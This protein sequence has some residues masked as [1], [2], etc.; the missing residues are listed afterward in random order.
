M[1]L[2]KKS[3]IALI[4]IVPFLLWMGTNV[5]ASSWGT[6]VV[7]S[8][9]EEDNNG[10]DIFHSIV[11]N[12]RAYI[13]MSLP[14]YTLTD[15][16]MTSYV[17]NTNH[18]IK[19]YDPANIWFDKYIW[20]PDTNNYNVFVI[21]STDS[22]GNYLVE[23]KS[24][25][26]FNNVLRI[27]SST[28]SLDVIASIDQEYGPD[29]EQKIYSLE[30]GKTYRLYWAKSSIF[31]DI[32]I[33]DLPETYGSPYIDGEYGTVTF[34]L[35]GSQLKVSI[36]YFNTYNLKTMIIDDITVFQN[37]T[38]AF[39][40]TEN[41]QKFISMTYEEK[42]PIYLSNLP[43]QA[44]PW[45]QTVSWNLDTNEIRSLNKVEVFAYHTKD[46]DR[47]ISTLM[48]MPNVVSDNIISVT[49]AFSY[50]YD[51]HFTG[52][53][54]I[55]TDTVTLI[56]GVKNNYSPTWEKKLIS[57]LYN[58]MMT[59]YLAGSLFWGLFGVD[60]SHLNPIKKT[61][62]QIQI[63]GY[64]STELV[65]TIT[66]AWN[67]AY[68]TNVVIDTNTNTL[69][70][71]NWGQYDK[72]GAKDVYMIENTFTFAEIVFTQDGKVNLLTFDDIILKDVVGK[73]LEPKDSVN[74]LKLIKDFIKKYP[75]ISIGIGVVLLIL[76]FLMLSSFAPLVTL[77]AS[78]LTGLTNLLFS[79]L[80]KPVF[81]V[82]AI[83]SYSI[84]YITNKL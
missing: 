57:T 52:K 77:F 20:N 21:E 69:Y 36:F 64:P 40:W 7:V 79:L 84:Y 50:Q 9:P 66:D 39:Y 51:Y 34:S 42:D 35:V 23:Y 68:N 32:E 44:R 15:S 16:Y 8:E 83:I 59:G 26:N 22:Q 80:T 43:I 3:L 14:R 24:T 72:F 17:T 48:Y 18:E 1:A 75:E 30:P 65:S 19:L 33:V 71:L 6:G 4:L 47:M 2:I 38:K 11:E 25:E 82:I 61:M 60:L 55:L 45:T 78:I 53:G 27:A 76:C 41:G 73:E 46:K 29:L 56:N 5:D 74:Y 70:K 28:S 58:P 54:E 13:H 67:D 10:A 37:V 49:A 81:W 12:Q 63:V 62:D 31:N